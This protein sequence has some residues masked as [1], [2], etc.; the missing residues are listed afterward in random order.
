MTVA[1][2][3][4]EDP[5]RSVLTGA[6]LMGGFDAD[7]IAALVAPDPTTAID[8]IE[9]RH[10]VR[11]TARGLNLPI[12]NEMRTWLDGYDP[13]G[14]LA[15]GLMIVAPHSHWE[16]GLPILVSRPGMH[17]RIREAMPESE[18]RY[19]PVAF[20]LGETVP[21]P[22]EWA[23][24]SVDIPQ[25]QHSA[26][27]DAIAEAADYFG[28]RAEHLGLAINYRFKHP[29]A[30][31]EIASAEFPETDAAEAAGIVVRS[32]APHDATGVETSGRVLEQVG[33][34]ARALR[35][36]LPKDLNGVFDRV[37]EL[38]DALDDE[39][40]SELRDTL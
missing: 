29:I 6:A 24:G 8:L 5:A 18:G 31:E 11:P 32:G 33:W 27:V 23:D 7:R 12:L 17:Y 35:P 14:L 13:S 16:K 20:A 30:P 39:T 4:P 3:R 19:R 22:Y 26:L 28:S 36:G 25:D 37:A 2:D 15:N 21:V 34:S 10:G 9:T 1:F 40:R 38:M